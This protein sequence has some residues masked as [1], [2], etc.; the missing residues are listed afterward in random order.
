MLTCGC[1]LCWGF[2]LI[3]HDKRTCNR[4][5]RFIGHKFCHVIELHPKSHVPLSWINFW[6]RNHWLSLFHPW[7][8]DHSSIENSWMALHVFLSIQYEWNEIVNVLYFI[9]KCYEISFVKVMNK[10][11]WTE[12]HVDNIPLTNVHSW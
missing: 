12:I 3:I 11:P 4:W 9:L 2:R 8:F 5:Y 6:T 1:K 7:K 10:N